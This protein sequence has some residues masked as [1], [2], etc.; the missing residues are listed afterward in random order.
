MIVSSSHGEGGAQR[1]AATLLAH[2]DRARFAPSLCLLKSTVTYPVPD[3]VPIHA[4]GPARDRPIAELARTKPWV[5]GELLLGLR[6][7][8]ERDRPDVVV[9]MMD[10]VAA[11][12]ATA[13]VGMRR[14]PAFVVR[15][16]TDPVKLGGFSQ[17]WTGWA[18]DR[19]DAVIVSSPA[20]GERVEHRYP[21]ARGRVRCLPNLTDFAR[22]DAMAAAPPSRTRDPAR[23][24]LIAVG[25]LS[26]E[27]R[28]ELMLDALARLGRPATLWMCGDGAMTDAVRARIT[29]LGVDA[30]VL[31][32]C[33]NPYALMRQADLLVLASDFEG[34]PN[35][36][37]EA[38][39]LGVPV[40][41]TDCDFGPRD[42]IADG[43][44]GLLVPRGDADALAAAIARLLDDPARRAAM[45]T[46]ARAKV[47]AQF[48]VEHLIGE[49]QRVLDGAG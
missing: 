2:L 19:A 6:R 12:T 43:E 13:M 45:G 48:G 9:A 42:V 33:D 24:L 8:I 29:E 25:R 7:R 27:K 46:A 36:V 26:A 3:D 32:F 23:P 30:H 41:S 11:V 20:L 34:Q 31:G 15:I 14:R 28:P 35:A 22:L 49:W 5:V 4:L 44:T 16:A 40:V 10:Q 17:A 1:V 21:R 47:R 39:G 37:I 18:I 38:Q